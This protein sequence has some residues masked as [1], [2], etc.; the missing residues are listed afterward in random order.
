M[1]L[2]FFN[3]EN[4]SVKFYSKDFSKSFSKGLVSLQKHALGPMKALISKEV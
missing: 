2:G 4:V 1:A 3:V